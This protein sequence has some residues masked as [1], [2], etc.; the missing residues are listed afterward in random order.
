MMA[1]IRFFSVEVVMVTMRRVVEEGETFSGGLFVIGGVRPHIGG[2]SLLLL[3]VENDVIGLT[4]ITVGDY[5]VLSV[6]C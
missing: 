6:V 4:L 2:G 5:L 1:M 3:D